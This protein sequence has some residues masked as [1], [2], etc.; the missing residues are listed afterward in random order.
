MKLRVFLFLARRARDDGGEQTPELAKY[1]NKS[2][3][4]K[5]QGQ[6]PFKL[7]RR[8]S[9]KLRNRGRSYGISHRLQMRISNF[10]GCSMLVS[11]KLNAKWDSSIS[12]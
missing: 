9:I 12:S 4:V 7:I 8:F 6:T 2:S 1:V 5:R 10:I 3:L 11:T